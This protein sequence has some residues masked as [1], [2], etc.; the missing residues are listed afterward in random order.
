M[1]LKITTA[2]PLSIGGQ[3]VSNVIGFLPENPSFKKNEDGS[4]TLI[5]CINWWLSVADSTANKDQVWP[6]GVNGSKI[7]DAP[8]G[9]IITEQEFAG[10]GL[11]LTVYNKVAAA[12]EAANTGYTVTVEQ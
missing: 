7:T 12:L 10:A 3:P 4:R 9:I 2:T 6:L 8:G 11:P 1:N 5:T